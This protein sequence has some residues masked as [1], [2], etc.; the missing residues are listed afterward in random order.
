MGGVRNEVEE[1]NKKIKFY[2]NS[3]SVASCHIRK[4]MG[5]SFTSSD[6]CDML[7]KYWQPIGPSLYC[8]KATQ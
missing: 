8:N 3:F 2:I 1:F 5:N 4:K 6:P 7:N